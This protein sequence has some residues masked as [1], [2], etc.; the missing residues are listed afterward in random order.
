MLSSIP[1]YMRAFEQLS[2]G[3]RARADLA[4]RLGACSL[5]EDLGA[6]VDSEIARSIASAVQRASN[7]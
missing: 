6:L 3:E 7:R 1:S 5:L 2:G 4:R